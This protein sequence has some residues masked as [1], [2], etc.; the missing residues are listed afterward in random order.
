MNYEAMDFWWKVAI[1]VLNGG[2]CIYMYLVTRNRVTNERIGKLQENVDTRLDDH[3]VRLARIEQDAHH[4]P[5][6]EDLKRIHM[7]IDQTAQSM[8]RIEG[9]FAGTNHTL[10]LIHE[11]LLNGGNNK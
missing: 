2:F 7:R 10:N 8:A 9:E 4:A 6:H 1:T 11:Y 3:A 5:T